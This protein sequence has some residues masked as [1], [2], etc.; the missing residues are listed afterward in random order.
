[1]SISVAAIY[2]RR[3][4]LIMRLSGGILFILLVGGTFVG[5]AIYYAVTSI[6]RLRGIRRATATFGGVLLAYGGAGFFGIAFAAS[7]GL[8]ASFEW[9]VGR[10][11]QLI[12]LDAERHLAVHTP[13][14]RIQIYDSQWKF[15]Y[16]WSVHA[17]AGDF[18]ARLRSDD[19]LDVWTARGDMHFL[20]S[21]EG[22]ELEASSYTENYMTLSTT[23]GAGYVPTPLLLWPFAHPFVGW[24]IGLAG[25]AMLK[26]GDPKR[27]ENKKRD[28]T[29][30]VER[31]K[32]AS[33]FSAL[34]GLVFVV[35]GISVTVHMYSL[36]AP[37]FV[38]A[39]AIVWTLG[40]ASISVYNS[41]N[42][43]SRP[44]PDNDAERSSLEADKRN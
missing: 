7:E 44:V 34:I 37:W 40:A 43:L 39:F 29:N 3:K 5:L 23:G 20:F 31:S 24:G 25:L 21:L 10:A 17:G 33:S 2:D 30:Q 38:K 8:P 12:E 6:W 27:F 13:S 15:L 32:L 9:P 4:F 1:M 14:S 19:V 28:A 11:D 16:G 41:R 22:K 18:K 35:V 36:G 26:Y 42:L